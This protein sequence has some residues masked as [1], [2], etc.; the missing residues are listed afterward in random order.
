MPSFVKGQKNLYKRDQSE[1]DPEK[2]HDGVAH[3]CENDVEQT[4]D[5]VELEVTHAPTWESI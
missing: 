5:G 1:T 3:L 2:C 4:A